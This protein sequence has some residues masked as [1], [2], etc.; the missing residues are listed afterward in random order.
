M[1]A[2]PAIFLCEPFTKSCGELQPEPCGLV[3]FGASGDLTRRKLL[4][5]L[6][7]LYQRRRLP[8]RFYILGCARSAYTPEEFRLSL[9]KEFPTDSINAAEFT[10]F[11]KHIDYLAGDYNSPVFYEE[12]KES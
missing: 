12:L 10:A 8:A 7:R 11:F 2:S 9:Q 6:W 3:I 1:S 4:P 5:S